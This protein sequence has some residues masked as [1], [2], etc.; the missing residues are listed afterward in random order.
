M[1]QK[2]DTTVYYMQNNFGVVHN[3]AIAN[4]IRIIV[5]P[6]SSSDPKLFDIHDFYFNGKT[7][8]LATAKSVPT[9]THIIL[10]GPEVEY[11][12]N[13]H[14]QSVTT[15]TNGAVIGDK[16]AYYPNG[17]LYY[18]E[19]YG[20]DGQLSLIECRDSTGNK[21]T[22]NGNGQ[23]VNFDNNFTRIIDS[24]KVVNGMAE[25]EWHDREGLSAIIFITNYNNNFIVS[26]NNPL[27]QA[28]MRA[29]DRMTV[30]VHATFAG[31]G[32]IDDFLAKNLKYPAIDLKNH[33]EGEVVLIFLIGLDGSVSNINV[34]SGPDAS[35]EKEAVRILA[36]TRWT[37]AVHNARK[38]ITE[39]TATVK[40][41]LPDNN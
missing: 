20:K 3:K 37:P 16:F 7:K 38:I 33:V 27:K 29:F 9:P 34:V 24:G 41:K 5:T 23:W 39:G 6:D 10:Q 13:G 18:K 8:M 35:L 11:Y 12:G 31:P 21:L 32:T 25:N 1:A 2:R 40:F 14:R 28:G 19:T 36:P 30:N 26:T 15:Y 4:Y 17:K 22:D